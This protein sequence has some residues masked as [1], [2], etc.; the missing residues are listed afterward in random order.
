MGAV[1][2]SARAAAPLK[3]GRERKNL[4]IRA[5]DALKRFV[6]SGAYQREH[7]AKTVF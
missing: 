5:V 6:A 4:D 7:D 1:P 3:Y 2:P